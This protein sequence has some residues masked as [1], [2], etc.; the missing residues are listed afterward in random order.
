MRSSPNNEGRFMV[1][2]N[3]FFAGVG[4]T[5]VILAIGFGGGLMMAKTAM[6]P[7][8]FEQAR[9]PAPADATPPIR[10][11]LPAS[12]EPAMPP[13][14]SLMTPQHTAQQTSSPPAAPAPAVKEAGATPDKAVEKV[15]TRKAEADERE[16]RKRAAERKARLASEKARR[17][18]QPQQREVAERRDAPI[19][20]FGSDEAPRRSG[21][22]FF[23]ND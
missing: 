8:A 22:G 1:S 13:Q 11:I 3:S 9:S 17:Q 2:A 21:F 16:R 6:E 10:V 4:T 20:A 14:P 5:F 19:M 7:R 12:S 15:D 18:Q 23:G